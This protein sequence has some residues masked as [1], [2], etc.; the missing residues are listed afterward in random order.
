M[1]SQ[2]WV[3]RLGK[4]ALSFPETF[5]IVNTNYLEQVRNLFPPVVR[6]T[7]SCAQCVNDKKLF[8]ESSTKEKVKN[9]DNVYK[10]AI[11]K[12]TKERKTRP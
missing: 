10:E 11:L 9:F 2:S 3:D 8:G 5:P 4:H 6:S 1:D 7:C 12:L